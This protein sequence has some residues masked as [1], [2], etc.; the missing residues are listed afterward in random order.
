MPVILKEETRSLAGGRS[1][2]DPASMIRPPKTMFSGDVSCLR[3]RSA[4][5]ALRRSV[6]GY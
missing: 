1:P 5:G 4:A 6:N 2:Q 3:R